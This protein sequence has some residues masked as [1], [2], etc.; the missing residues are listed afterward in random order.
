MFEQFFIYIIIIKLIQF[1]CVVKIYAFAFNISIRVQRERVL[2]WTNEHGCIAEIIL[3]T[4]KL[5]YIVLDG[6]LVIRS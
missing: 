1:I 4:D 6:T 5:S 3:G 2:N